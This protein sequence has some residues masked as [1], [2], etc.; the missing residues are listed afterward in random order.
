MFQQNQTCLCGTPLSTWIT[1]GHW[2]RR[3]ISATLDWSCS[4][5]APSHL[6]PWASL[7]EKGS[8][9]FPCIYMNKTLPR[10]HC[11]YLLHPICLSF[12]H[13]PI[14]ISPWMD[15][16]HPFDTHIQTLKWTFQLPDL[17]LYLAVPEKVDYSLSN[18]GKKQNL[19]H[20]E[21]RTL[22][23][24]GFPFPSPYNSEWMSERVCLQRL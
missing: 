20:S 23:T 14:V 8:D 5:T 22:Q 15:C 9:A 13:T 17:W 18:H 3:R 2:L 1:K 11:P 6:V 12:H 7:M 10:S 16:N 21:N 24:L 4:P 19:C